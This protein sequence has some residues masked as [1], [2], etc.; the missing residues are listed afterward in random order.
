MTST[1]HLGLTVTSNKPPHKSGGFVLPY[2]LIAIA[3]LAA[4][5]LYTAQNLSR[6]ADVLLR[7]ERSREIDLAF[8][9]AET[10]AL[11]WLLT[12]R[13]DISGYQKVRDVSRRGQ[14]AETEPIGPKWG[15]RGDMRRINTS[16]GPVFV[17]LQDASGLVSL[18]Q[19][20]EKYFADIMSGF[21]IAPSESSRLLA[22]LLDYTDQDNRRRFQGAEAV[23]Y[24]QKNLPPPTNQNLRSLS[25]LPRIMGWP[26]ALAQIDMEKFERFV[27]LSDRTTLTREAHLSPELAAHINARAA[28]G[29][30]GPGGSAVFTDDQYPSAVFRLTF[31]APIS[32]EQG[33]VIIRRRSAEYT[34]TVN[35]M[36]A[37]MKKIW[38]SDRTVLDSGAFGRFNRALT[39]NAGQSS[40]A[41]GTAPIR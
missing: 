30:A 31:E 40:N 5:T 29:R 28:L 27:T 2:V 41:S 26:E 37:P 36:A 15:V 1:S 23:Q 10:E 13:P 7:L 11:L 19:P 39:L 9:A 14:L 4:V 8:Q 22:A 12:A 34:R 6:G 38:I 20:D 25:E 21:N 17:S 3:L 32:N 18:R 16:F 24:R 35:L 33:Q